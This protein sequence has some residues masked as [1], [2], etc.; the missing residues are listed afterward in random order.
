MLTKTALNNPVMILMLAVAVVVLGY[1]SVTRIP[2]DLFPDITMPMVLVGVMYPG[3]G[4]KDIE[5]SITEQLERAVSSV[6]GVSYIESTSRQGISTVRANFAWGTD[7]DVAAS[8]AIQRVQQM[9]NA[10]PTGALSPFVIKMDVSNFAIVGLNLYGEGI[11]ERAMYDLAYNVI[12]PQLERVPGVSTASISGGLTRQIQIIADRD[13]LASRNLT[14]QDV[15]NALSAANF[16]L[17]SGMLKVGDVDFNV[18]AITQISDVDMLGDVVIRKGPGGNSP[19][20]VRD[21][22]KVIDGAEDKTNIVR[23]NGVPGVSLWVRKQPG[24]N[25]IKVVQ[26]VLAEI[27]K[28][29]GIPPGMTL[30]PA[31]DQST[32]IRQSINSLLNEAL[33]GGL[34]AMAVIFLFLRSFS[35]TFIIS[36]AIPLSI[37]ATFILLYFVGGQSLNTFTLGGLALGVGRLVDDS[38]VVLENIF[39]HRSMGKSGRQAAYDGAKE[40]AMPVLASTIAT[41]AVFFPV[42]FLVGIAKLLFIPLTLTIVFALAAS[43]LVAMAVIPPL[44]VRFKMSSLDASTRKLGPIMG[45]WQAALDWTGE[46]YEKALRWGLNHKVFVVTLV[47]LLF[48]G[49][50]FMLPRIGT[51]FFPATDESQFWISIRGPLGTRVERTVES[52]YVVEEAITAAL[53]KENVSS[54]VSDA[55]IRQSSGGSMWSRNPGPHAANVR[56]RLVPP[57][58]RPFSDKEAVELVRKELAGKLPGVRLFFDAGGMQRRIMNFGSEAPLDIEIVGHDLEQARLL[59]GQIREIVESIPGAVDVRVSREDD[60]PELDIAID[61]EKAARLG[62][63]TREVAQG[64][65]TSVAGNLN[66]PGI[67]SDPVTGHEYHI[68][69]R[70]QEQD[71]NDLYDLED[72]PLVTTDGQVLTLRTVADVVP[73]AGPVQ[74]DKKYMDRVVHVTANVFGRSLGDVAADVE[75][76]LADI[77]LPEGFTVRLGGERSQQQESFMGLF[78]AMI[79]AL[80]LVYMTMASQFKSLREPFIVMFSVPMGMIGVVAALWLT[81]TPLSVNAFMGIIMMVGIV[82][83][84]GILLVDFAN[85]LADEGLDVTEAVVQAGRIRLRPIL[86]TTA[87]SLLG[88]LPMAVGIGEGSETNVPLARAVVGGLTASTVFTLVLVPILYVVFRK[89]GPKFTD[90]IVTSESTAKDTN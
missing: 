87:T 49:A 17:P 32:Y 7:I 16:L 27:P 9:M 37:A 79:L 38:I 55:G 89:R 44:S 63:S 13:A 81:S 58:D 68:I 74:I 43:Y 6:P 5:A 33:M 11:D 83:S 50:M 48:S 56:V 18:F 85:N 36:L 10:L 60:Y 26:D 73:A 23:I 54:I 45:A 78:M 72:V 46:F 12:Q 71:R 59:H 65:L 70:F 84:N 75:E 47:A 30:E 2:V 80:M 86:M 15:V 90:P 52:V 22:A 67:Y 66:I 53:G 21:V 88:L 77:V 64:V 31:F 41:I 51:E 3:A 28:I 29:R 76:K 61:R 19:I 62:L 25:T 8:D 4:P 34:L 14:A 40:V 57:A 1:V 35:S 69:V 39:R 42:I 20:F 24:A 82:V